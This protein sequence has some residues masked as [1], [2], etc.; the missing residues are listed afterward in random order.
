[1][2]RSRNY[3]VCGMYMAVLLLLSATTCNA[4]LTSFLVKVGSFSARKI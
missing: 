2:T 4:E 3:G 1:M